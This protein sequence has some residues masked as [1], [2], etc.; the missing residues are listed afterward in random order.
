MTTVANRRKARMLWAASL[1]ASVLALAGCS[2][3]RTVTIDSDP[4]GARIHKGAEYLGDAPLTIELKEAGA[5]SSREF[6]T[7]KASKRGYM[8]ST[9]VIDNKKIPK[10]LLFELQKEPPAPEAQKGGGQQQQMQQQMQGPT[11]VIPGG[12]KP[13][14]VEPGGTK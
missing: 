11:I 1:A 2:T 7:I 3:T 12:G 9:K 14:K 6:F 8:S 4:P 5:F 10:R 13:I